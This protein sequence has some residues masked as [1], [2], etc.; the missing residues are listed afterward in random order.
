MFKVVADLDG[1]VKELKP[2]RGSIPFHPT[3]ERHPPSARER[4]RGRTLQGLTAWPVV[5]GRATHRGW[6]NS[7]NAKGGGTAGAFRSTLMMRPYY[8]VHIEW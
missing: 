3:G 2:D 5:Q 8:K 4:L 1:P 6:S 7:T